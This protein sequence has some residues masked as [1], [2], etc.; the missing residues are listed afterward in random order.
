MLWRPSL[1]AVALS[2]G[3]LAGCSDSSLPPL[4]WAG[5]TQNEEESNYHLEPYH[6]DAVIRVQGLL[7]GKQHLV[8]KPLT[9]E[10]V[11][12]IAED[13]LTAVGKSTWLTGEDLQ[14][15]LSP[16]AL[17]HWRQAIEGQSLDLVIQV[18]S[19]IHQRQEAWV[20]LRG[21]DSAAPASAGQIMPAQNDWDGHMKAWKAEDGA[22]PLVLLTPDETIRALIEMRARILDPHTTLVRPDVA[23]TY[24]ETALR[25][26][27]GVGIVLRAIDGRLEVE[28]LIPDAPAD[29]DGSLKVG[30]QVVAIQVSGE[31][32]KNI[33]SL[34]KAME[35]LRSKA[36]WIE[37]RIKRNGKSLTVRLEPSDYANNVESLKAY[38]E[39]LPAPNGQKIKS[40]RLEATFFYEDGDEKKSIAD[41]IQE[42]LANARDVDVVVLDFRRCR[43]GALEEALKVSGLFVE[44]GSLGQLRMNGDLKQSLADPMPGQYWSGPLQI[45]V[46]PQ[47]ASSAELVAQTLRDR[48]KGAQ[49]LGWPTYGKGTLQ[50][51]LELDMAAVRNNK[52]SRLGELWYTVAE[53]YSPSGRSM[54]EQGVALDGALPNAVAQPW[55][56]RSLVGALAPTPVA[57]EA[58]ARAIESAPNL[59]PST[60]DGR[61]LGQWRKAAGEL[62]IH[63]TPGT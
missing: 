46:G 30:D 56:E 58:K 62:L 57:P 2:I 8:G 49:V 59:T 63:P 41:E 27:H 4:D 18:G 37:L 52:S 39:I 5:N 12:K 13:F 34:E 16:E 14:A 55:G 10:Q 35:L 40:L 43:G 31:E 19:L 6:Q 42:A 21:Q 50:K 47:T 22:S 23:Q 54:Q 45:W 61:G 51:R 36:P 15:L 48:V 60:P 53:I 44:G 32:W 9:D 1:L 11:L 25:T 17:P 33:A 26:A 24:N 38:K 29:R 20:K 7:A 3:L 28:T